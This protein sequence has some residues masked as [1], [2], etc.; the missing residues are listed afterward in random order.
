MSDG[1]KREAQTIE[2]LTVAAIAGIAVD[3]VAPFTTPETAASIVQFHTAHGVIMFEAV[4]RDFGPTYIVWSTMRYE[5]DL[6]ARG[7]VH[8]IA[9]ARQLIEDHHAG[10]RFLAVENLVIRNALTIDPGFGGPRIVMRAGADYARVHIEDSRG[11]VRVALDLLGAGQA[12]VWLD[13]AMGRNRATIG[14]FDHGAAGL[15]LGDF[16]ERSVTINA[17]VG[18]HLAHV[19]ITN[20][21]SPDVVVGPRSPE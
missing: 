2:T 1:P 8:R 15:I 16:P 20:E 12:R 11:V 17:P 4:A 5:D 10:Q 18:S 21:G 13:D 19:L 6:T 9:E 3:G 14:V 7:V